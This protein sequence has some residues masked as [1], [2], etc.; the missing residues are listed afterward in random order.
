VE[1]A[2]RATPT[3]F[4]MKRS[5]ANSM[6]AGEVA[7]RRWWC[8]DGFADYTSRPYVGINDDLNLEYPMA[9]SLP[10]FHEAFCASIC[11]PP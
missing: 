1:L 2:A 3:P 11:V 7:A 9:A 6:A 4:P 5:L 8:R 10:V